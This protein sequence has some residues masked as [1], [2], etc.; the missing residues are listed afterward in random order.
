[1]TDDQTISS[2]DSMKEFT[3]AY[4]AGLM[5][6]EGCFSIYK[7]ALK[8]SGRLVYQPRIVISSVD[9][10]LIKWLVATFGG[11]Y[12]S[13]VPK[14]GRVW[15]QWNRNGRKS[16][17]EFL[18]DIIPYLRVKKQ[19]ALILKKFYELKA[20]TCDESQGLMEGIRQLKDRE[21]STTETLDGSITD[22]LTHAY[23]A[24]I[25][26]GEGCISVGIAPSGKPVL[27]TQ[28]GNNYKPLIEFLI[29]IYGGWFDSIPARGNSKESHRWNVT[30]KELREKF[31]SQIL[32][33]LRI[34]KE[35][36]KL[37]LHY[38]QLPKEG[39]REERVRIGS[40]IKELN[41]PKIRPALTS[42][43]ECASAEMLTA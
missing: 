30:T 16:A 10:P 20:Y 22:K 19:E 24:G 36:A 39:S 8:P 11:F 25:F 18:S 17:T 5:D 21:C 42:D 40:L 1:M 26:D 43:R 27:H 31:L 15:Y 41:R 4:M 34:K 28:V 12:T 6:A 32:P 29:K 13:H 23:L 2:K 9:L 7:V 37:A 14:K 33:Y 3:K 38:I 35:Q